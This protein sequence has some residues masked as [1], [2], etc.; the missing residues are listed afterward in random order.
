PEYQDE[1]EARRE[2]IR[3]AERDGLCGADILGSGLA[4]PLEVFVSPGGY[5]QG[6]ETALLEALED[7]R[8]EPRNK[9]PFPV[10]HGL[11]GRPTVINN[12]ETLDWVPA[13]V[14]PDWAGD[15]DQGVRGSGGLGCG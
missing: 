5:I 8:G 15:P 12:V 10:T 9:P 1:M 4:L 14:L 6:E 2:A 3:Q 11:H 7:R 13:V